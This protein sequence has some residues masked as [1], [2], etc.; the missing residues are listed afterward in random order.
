M[1][2]DV[3][4]LNFFNFFFPTIIFN[5]QYL[6]EAKTCSE[7]TRTSTVELSG[8]FYFL[9]FCKIQKKTPA[10]VKKVASPYPAISLKT[11]FLETMQSHRE[12]IQ[13]I[14]SNLRFEKQIFFSTR[15]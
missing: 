10:G 4:K 11:D 3:S 9:F 7:P 2:S 1:F 14:I 6:P 12:F 8:I 13:K 15:L 5:Y